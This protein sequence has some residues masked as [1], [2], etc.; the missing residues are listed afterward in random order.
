MVLSRPEGRFLVKSEN[1]YKYILVT[2]HLGYIHLTPLKSRSSAFS[3]V[4]TF[5]E[6]VS[7]FKTFSHPLTHLMI[8]KQ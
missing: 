4:S 8:D 1:G 5:S 3:Y 7:F 6:F 2:V